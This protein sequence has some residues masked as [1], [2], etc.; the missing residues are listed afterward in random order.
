MSFFPDFDSFEFQN[1]AFFWFG[2]TSGGLTFSQAEVYVNK[3]AFIKESYKNKVIYNIVKEVLYENILKL[4]KKCLGTIENFQCKKKVKYEQKIRTP[5]FAVFDTETSG[6]SKNDFVIQLAVVTYDKFGDTIDSY[7]KYWSLPPGSRINP[8]SQSIHN[9]S[10]KI[11]QEKGISP[12]KEF[13]Y[14]LNLFSDFIKNGITLV[15]HNASYDNRM[16]KQTAEYYNFIWPFSTEHFFC[17]QKASRIYV[18]ALD[19]NGNVKAPKNTELYK[20]IT[21]N[22]PEGDLHNALVDCGITATGYLGGKKNG[23]W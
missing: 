10:Y 19:K 14:I 23:L 15:A 8:I 21:G 3:S 13:P 7:N 22:N 17:T 6:N 16:L 18:R 20:F 1:D 2:L 9:I 5:L 4:E 11:L 12:E